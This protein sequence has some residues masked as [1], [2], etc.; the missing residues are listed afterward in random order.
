MNA[1]KAIY[2]LLS[3]NAPLVAAVNGIFARV[4]AQGILRPFLV[5]EEVDAILQPIID[6]TSPR[7]W[8]ARIQIT[9]IAD[10]YPTV[11]SV[12][13]KASAACNYARGVIGGVTVLSVVK[14]S[15]GSDDFDIGTQTFEQ[16]FDLTVL[17]L[18]DGS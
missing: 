7:L 2:A 6:P 18:D 17:Y 5:Y 1:S 16:S 13:A 8:Q 14:E 12:L 3:G 9:A 10:D 4:A 11:K 15:V